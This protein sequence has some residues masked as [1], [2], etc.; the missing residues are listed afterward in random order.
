MAKNVALAG[1]AIS[2]GISR[3][4]LPPGWDRF[5]SRSSIS[6]CSAWFQRPRNLLAVP[7]GTGALMANLGALVTGTWL[8]GV[9]VLFNH[10]AW[11]FMT[12]MT[13]V[14]VEAAKIP[15]A[16][17]YVPDISWLAIAIYYAAIMVLFGGWPKSVRAK[18][19][20]L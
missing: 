12:A 17:F 11:G 13:W 8:P 15:A 10:A 16:Y 18:L 6:T 14:S 1:C 20:S 9:T 5:R 4:P 19:A 2:R 3:W 7:L